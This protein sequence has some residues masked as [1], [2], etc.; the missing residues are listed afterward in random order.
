MRGFWALEAVFVL[1]LLPQLF[2][3]TSTGPELLPRETAEITH[4]IAQLLVAGHPP[5]EIEGLEGKFTV[6]ING[7]QFYP[8]PYIFRYCTSRRL[9]DHQE[10]NICAA[11][12][13]T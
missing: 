4:V 3:L 12:C 8:C 1:L 7:T 9:P 10:V 5:G 13:S 11:A 2:F 6:W